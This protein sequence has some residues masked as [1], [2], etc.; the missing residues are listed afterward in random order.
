MQEDADPLESSGF[1]QFPGPSPIAV[2][3]RPLVGCLMASRWLPAGRITHTSGKTRGKDEA[4]HLHLPR[5]SQSLSLSSG[6][7]EL[8]LQDGDRPGCTG[9]WK[10]E[11]LAFR[12]VENGKGRRAGRRGGRVG[13][14]ESCVW[15][16]GRVPVSLRFLWSESNPLWCD[17]FLAGVPLAS[18]RFSVQVLPQK[19]SSTRH[20]N[21]PASLSRFCG[22]PGPAVRRPKSWAVALK[23][24]EQQVLGRGQRCSSDLC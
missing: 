6:I 9:S 20:V 17:G 11:S 7:F 1:F 15:T 23:K 12:S 21:A 10:R 19:V 24:L 14:R 18:R 5:L 2:G 3:F 8:D 13:Q 22:F 4:Q 16:A